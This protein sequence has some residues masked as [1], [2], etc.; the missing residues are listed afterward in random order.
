MYSEEPPKTKKPFY[1]NKKFWIITCSIVLGIYVLFFVLVKTGVVPPGV[2]V[3]LEN[4]KDTITYEP[5]TII[6]N[7]E[8][9][10]NYYLYQFKYSN[11]KINVDSE[12]Y[13]YYDVTIQFRI[14]TQLKINGVDYKDDSIHLSPCIVFYSTNNVNFEKKINILTVENGSTYDFSFKIPNVCGG[15]EKEDPCFDY[16]VKLTVPANL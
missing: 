9:K 8:F 1:K 12:N 4:K 5:S 7:T 16:Y 15:K 13:I 2:H 3:Y 10:V 11:E 14:K 6:E